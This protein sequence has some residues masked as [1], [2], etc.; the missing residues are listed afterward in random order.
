MVIKVPFGRRPECNKGTI[1][2]LHRIEGSKMIL[3]VIRTSVVGAINTNSISVV[4]RHVGELGDNSHKETVGPRVKV[5]DVKVHPGN[6]ISFCYPTLTKHNLKKRSHASR[7]GSDVPSTKDDP[8][9]PGS[10]QTSA[11][12][13]KGLK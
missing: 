6:R 2:V 1:R 7:N 3:D 5:T 9:Y 13:R 10:S 8:G 12:A 4:R 11:F